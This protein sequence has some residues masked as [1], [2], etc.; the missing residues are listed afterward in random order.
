M[1]ISPFGR[2][3]SLIF[4]IFLP[5]RHFESVSSWFK[6]IDINLLD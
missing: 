5:Y 1:E 3:D 4:K 2:D 6:S